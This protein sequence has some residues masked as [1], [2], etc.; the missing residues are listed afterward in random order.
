MPIRW[1][2]LLGV[3]LA[4]AVLPGCGSSS[5]SSR[6][7][8]GGGS[9]SSHLALV[10]IPLQNGVSVY[11]VSGSG[12]LTVAAGSA[13]AAGASPSSIWVHPSGNFAY[14]INQQEDDISLLKID[15]STG[16]LTEV[17]PRT[18]T[19]VNPSSLGFGRQFS[20]CQQPGVE[21]DLRLFG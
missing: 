17:K 4:V 20:L 8:G 2:V 14:V 6:S 19:G 5:G 7:G 16:S 12:S 3:L 21:H 9:S 10:S 15:S 1:K 18:P 13:F 11:R